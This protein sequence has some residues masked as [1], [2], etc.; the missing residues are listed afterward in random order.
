M[1]S[2]GFQLSE[3]SFASLNFVSF[4]YLT[5]LVSKLLSFWIRFGYPGTLARELIDESFHESIEFMKVNV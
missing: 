3:E 2:E 4:G 5:Y 1:D